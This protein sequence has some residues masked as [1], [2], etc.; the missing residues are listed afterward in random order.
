VT[1]TTP[2]AAERRGA[3]NEP[4]ELGRYTIPDGERVIYGQRVLGIVRLVDI[5]A[6]GHGRRYIIERE[7]TVMA[8]VEAI[9][10]DY[11]DQ[12]VRWQLIPAAGSCC[13]AECAK[14]L[15]V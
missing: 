5:S 6:T 15:L 2:Q 7:L 14:E 11:L 1:P 13:L 10:E 4:V 8:E 9:V 12:A 3:T